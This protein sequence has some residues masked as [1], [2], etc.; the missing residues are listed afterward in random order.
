MFLNT[1]N[2]WQVQGYAAFYNDMLIKVEVGVTPHFSCLIH[3]KM[4]I[5]ISGL[6]D[7]ITAMKSWV[8]ILSNIYKISHLKLTDLNKAMGAGN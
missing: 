4:S 8:S 5:S 3:K 6:L 7:S 2:A 1:E